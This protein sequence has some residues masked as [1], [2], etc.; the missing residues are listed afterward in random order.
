[1]NAE[2][3]E[4]LI[5]EAKNYESAREFIEELGW[6][7]WMNEVVDSPEDEEL[8]DS[9]SKLIDDILREIFDEAHSFFN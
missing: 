4:R 8:T 5:K 2:I 3:R 9:Q 7:D 1:M 6:E